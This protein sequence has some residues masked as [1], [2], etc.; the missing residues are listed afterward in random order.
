MFPPPRTTLSTPAS[1]LPVNIFVDSSIRLFVFDSANFVVKA[2]ARN[3]Q[4]KIM[5]FCFH[6]S[7]SHFSSICF[8]FLHLARVYS[9]ILNHCGAARYM[10]SQPDA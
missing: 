4:K 6:K 3:H 5:F 10:L 1:C 9:A 2:A 8:F 7:M